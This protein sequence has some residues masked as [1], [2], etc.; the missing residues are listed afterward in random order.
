MIKFLELTSPQESQFRQSKIVSILVKEGDEVEVGQAMFRVLS[1]DQEIDL[2]STL[3]GRITEVIVEQGETISVMTSL[4]LIE[5]E[6]EKSTAST[7]INK[8][9]PK[10]TSSKSGVTASAP[11]KKSAKPPKK[12][13]KSAKKSSQ[14][15]TKANHK[16]G[17]KTGSS[18]SK[19]SST[20][21]DQQ[22]LN[23]ETQST[24]SDTNSGINEKAVRVPDIGTDTAKVIE[25][26]VDLNDQISVNDPIV[27]LE[28]DKASMEIPSS[29]AGAI[30]SVAVSLDQD[31]TEG[32]ILVTIAA[33][34]KINDN[35]DVAP[36]SVETQTSEESIDVASE[37]PPHS[38]NNNPESN[39][40]E[41]VDVRIPDIG[42][43]SAKVIE[44]F[45]SQ[46]AQV[47]KDEPLITLESDKASMDLP[48]PVAGT[49]K[50]VNVK[51]NDE[52]V[53]GDL[54]STIVSSSANNSTKDAHALTNDTPPIEGSV[55]AE[56][57]TT[58]S[59]TTQQRSVRSIEPIANTAS[60]STSGGT[61]HA[62]PSVRRFARELGADLGQVI[63]TGR[64]NRV[65]HEDVKH[66]VKQILTQPRQ[67]QAAPDTATG[68]PHI[69]IIDF[70]KFGDVETKPL[71]KIKRLTAA[72]LHRSWLNVPHVTHNDEANITDLESFRNQV[73]DKYK[74]QNKDIKL[75]PLAFIVKA[76]VNA[77]QTYP[78]FNASLDAIGEN[79]IYKKY[80]NIGIAVD[81]PNGL[82]VPVIRKADTLSVAEIAKTMSELSAK[83]RNKKLS[84][85]DMSGACFTISS[86]GGIGGTHFTPIVNAPEVAI[87]GV[88]RSKMQPIWNGSEFQ[89]GLMLPLSLSYDHR[90]IDGAE[91]ARFTRYLA[92]VLED[93]RLLSI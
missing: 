70:S 67:M 17:T 19:K 49:I 25:I 84:P 81:T 77:L 12:K 85:A 72:N 89:P 37:S 76:I 30:T 40:N 27:T 43:E 80:V 21:D 16:K 53:Q 69:P 31:V 45:V 42:A 79:L 13:T 1:G 48:C 73:N 36:K 33:N 62:S 6:V 35:N 2:P 23:L 22:S 58:Q 88:S 82:V 57:A 66:Y 4:V 8:D 51:L 75:S 3:K 39:I 50:S 68:I 15:K 28:S 65:T 18:D 38:A 32:D 86:L 90:V 55:S 78:Q 9:K 7:P 20:K 61:S 52:V 41:T 46:D 59:T 56:T 47:S 14:K 29:L 10:K 64:K 44:I 63:G 92:E 11:I 74:R 60:V 91:A 83:A 24:S 34:N 93:V 5:T 71:N 87:L 54:V 26:L